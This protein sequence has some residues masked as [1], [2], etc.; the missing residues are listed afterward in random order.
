MWVGPSKWDDGAFLCFRV[1]PGEELAL[2]GGDLPGRGLVP[3]PAPL[4]HTDRLPALFTWEYVGHEH[5]CTWVKR[6][7]C[8]YTVYCTVWLVTCV[9]TTPLTGLRYENG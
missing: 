7:I 9:I 5:R 8:T 4:L 3:G 1:W 2:L 6:T